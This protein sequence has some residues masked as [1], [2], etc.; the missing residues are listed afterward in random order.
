VT[1]VLIV[2]N[3]F[4][5]VS[6][7]PVER[8]KREGCE[9][10]EAYHEIGVLREDH[11]CELIGGVDAVIVSAVDTVNSR[12]IEAG[13]TLKVI[14]VRGVGYQGVNLETATTKGIMVTNTPGANA[15]AVADLTMGFIMALAKQIPMIDRRMRKGEWY[16]IRT[17]DVYGQTLGLIGLGGIGRKVVQRAKG[18]DMRMITYD[19]VKDPDFARRYHLEYVSFE[20]VLRT[21]DFVTLHVPLTDATKNLIGPEELTMMKPTAFLVNTARGGIVSEDALYTALK[22]GL[23]AGAACDVFSVE[24]TFNSRLL[25]LDNMIS[26]PHIGGY[27]DKCWSVMADVVVE[28]VL[29]ALRGEVPPNLVNPDALRRRRV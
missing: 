19:I 5:E 17:T 15:D 14:A 25:A 10:V 4:S 24:P 3:R 16:R 13:E 21:S 8:L 1:R 29:A 18:F 27:T 6:T 11:Y 22:T 20:D 2:A 12:V 7:K 28:N 9:V 23:I 26:T